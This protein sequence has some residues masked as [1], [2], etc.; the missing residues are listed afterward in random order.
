MDSVR[1]WKSKIEQAIDIYTSP[2]VVKSTYCLMERILDTKFYRSKTLS[3]FLVIF[4]LRFC[5]NLYLFWWCSKEIRSKNKWNSTWL[6]KFP[7]CQEHH[8]SRR[9]WF[10][11][12]GQSYWENKLCPFLWL[13]LYNLQCVIVRM[14]FIP[15]FLSH[16]AMES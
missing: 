11:Y 5:K 3:Y 8:I 15:P 14:S 12:I 16:I 4:R 6:E 2:W 7:D 13:T 1:T 10:L 9:N